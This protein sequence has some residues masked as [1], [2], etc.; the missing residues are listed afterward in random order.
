MSQR[1]F[2]TLI[3]CVA[4]VAAMQPVHGQS[5]AADGRW[6]PWAG[7][8]RPAMPGNSAVAF[9]GAGSRAQQTVCVVPLATDGSSVA[10]VVTIADGKIVATD[11]IAASGERR[12]RS[13]GGCNGYES[14]RWSYDGHRLYLNSDVV[15]GGSTRRVSA[16][17]F[18]IS[19]DGGWVNVESVNAGGARGVRAL[20]YD[21]V[22]APD[23]LPAALTNSWRN[24][25]NSTSASRAAAGAPL[26]SADVID[27]VRNTDSAVVAAWVLDRGQKFGL[28]AKQLIALSNA[29]VPSDVTDAMVAVSYPSAFAVTGAEGNAAADA[30]PAPASAAGGVLSGRRVDVMML[31]EY[32][33]YNISP[34]GWYGFGYSAFAYSP[35]GYP[36]FGYSP[37]G[38]PVVG[39]NGYGGYGGYYPASPGGFYGPPVVILRGTETAQR[40][41]VVN[42]RGYTRT[43]PA[44]VPPGAAALPRPA[45]AP[46]PPPPPPPSSPAPARTAHQRP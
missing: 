42:G 46:P 4:S 37:Y 24:A 35:Y 39:Y 3:T 30:E 11:T 21:A 22:S 45:A 23:A 36:S 19:P 25:I 2:A 7:C 40:G 15:C 32:S 13:A 20:R 18:A 41:Y 44:Y 28:D 34:F 8:W 43:P 38:S 33:P 31:P 16:G 5:A 6:Q 27:A 26:E 14:A 9:G 12:A 29:G 17:L 10:E 1:V